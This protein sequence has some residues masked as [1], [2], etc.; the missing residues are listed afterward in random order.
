[1]KLTILGNN[2]PFPAAGG[3]CSGYLLT[4]GSGKTRVLIECGTGTLANLSRLPDWNQL[5]AVILSHLH[6]DHMSDML[7]MQY[8]LQFNPR[9]N[10]LRVFAPAS[11]AHVRALLDVSA[12]APAPMGEVKIGEISFAFFPVRHPVEC[13][14]L[15]A[16]CDGRVFV[17]TGDTN[18]VNGLDSF[19]RDAHVLLADAGLSSGDW[20]ETAPHLSAELCANLA[21]SANAQKLLL[22]HLNPKYTREQLENEARAIRPDAAFV[23]IGDCF[24]I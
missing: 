22:T 6:F 11:P 17:Y 9:E 2:G 12:Y 13:Y 16:E 8:A 7:P 20:K 18:T 14:A 24:D 4:S 19:A 15:R 3:A 10:P 5:D 21:V 23:Q 1:M